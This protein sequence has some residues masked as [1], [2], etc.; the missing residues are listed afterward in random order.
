MKPDYLYRLSYEDELRFDDDGYLISHFEGTKQ[1]RRSVPLVEEKD[2]EA[3]ARFF[4]FTK[5]MSSEKPFFVLKILASDVKEKTTKAHQLFVG[6]EHHGFVH[7]DAIKSVLRGEWKH[8]HEHSLSEKF[9]NH[10]MG[11]RILDHTRGFRPTF[12]SKIEENVVSEILG[13]S[14]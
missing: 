6:E 11:A 5:L 8:D 14:K 3:I 12:G 4:L 1:D 2:L 10:L 9:L 7:R 13:K